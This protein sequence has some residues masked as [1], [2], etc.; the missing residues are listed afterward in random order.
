MNI[1]HHNIRPTDPGIT[2]GKVLVVD[3]DAVARMILS[4]W[5]AIWNLPTVFCPNALSALDVVSM[6]PFSL[7]IIDHNLPEMN[8]IE[9]ARRLRDALEHRGFTG[10]H[11]ALH[12]TDF[13]TREAAREHGFEYF[14]EKPL[15]SADLLLALRQSGCR[16]DLR[17]DDVT[18]R[19][20]RAR[21]D[22]QAEPDRTAFLF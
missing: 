5:M 10:T 13:D 7:A 12:T 4:R 17:Q 14:L 16:P 15:D 6:A 2:P 1:N 3:D 20:T 11:F 21:V 18:G 9:L 8:G 19:T 22:L